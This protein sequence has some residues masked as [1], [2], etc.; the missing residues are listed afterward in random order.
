M[1]AEAPKDRHTAKILGTVIALGAIGVG[2]YLIY[3]FIKKKSC[4]PLGAVKCVDGYEN[5][6]SPWPSESIT[7]ANLWKR[8]GEPCEG[9]RCINGD[10]RCVNSIPYECIGQQWAVGGDACQQPPQMLCIEGAKKCTVEKDKVQCQ[11]GQWKKIGLCGPTSCLS[12]NCN[13]YEVACDEDMTLFYAPACDPDAGGCRFTMYEPNSDVCK[14]VAI[15]KVSVTVNAQPTYMSGAMFPVSI[16]VDGDCRRPGSWLNDRLQ[17]YPELY[18]SVQVKDQLNRPIPGV[19][20]KAFKATATRSFIAF[21]D[22]N[23]YT[24]TDYGSLS[25]TKGSYSYNHPRSYTNANG[26]AIMRGIVLCAPADGVVR[27]E[28][29]NIDVSQGEQTVSLPI[30]LQ[31]M[32]KGDPARSCQGA[33]MGIDGDEC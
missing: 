33:W 27:T 23:D 29:F 25:Y 20:V 30:S 24:S 2:G 5:E 21:V 8:T 6:C 16:A 14:R 7:L 4:S 15:S 31:I 17:R 1:T 32:G 9:D 18:V 13:P 11:S 12:V 3:D 22:P 10:K 19:R 26:E 28:V